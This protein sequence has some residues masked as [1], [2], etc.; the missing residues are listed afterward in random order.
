MSNKQNHYQLKDE[1]KEK[2]QRETETHIKKIIKDAK[3]Q[4]KNSNGYYFEKL[5]N[6]Q[7]IR[8]VK[9]KINYDTSKNLKTRHRSLSKNN[10]QKF[11]TM[12][13]FFVSQPNI[14]S[15]THNKEMMSTVQDFKPSALTIHNN[16]K[17]LTKGNRNSNLSN[18]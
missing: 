2:L 11:K 5:R 8:D 3:A 1:E 12:S 6:L 4:M 15:I 13:Q 14:P 18:N 10:T 7:K 17:I 9:R 16:E